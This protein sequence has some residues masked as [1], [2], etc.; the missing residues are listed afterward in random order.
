MISWKENDKYL[1]GVCN[2]LDKIPKTMKIA[3]FDLDDTI[4][5]LQK[6]KNSGWQFIDEKVKTTMNDLIEKK[7]M[8]IIFTNQGGMTVSKN[9]D[10]KGWRQKINEI[11]KI[12]FADHAQHYFAIFAAKCYDMFRKPN[13][14]MWKVM[15]KSLGGEI[16]DKSF[17]CGDAAGR[18][19]KDVYGKKADFSDTDRKFALNIGLPFYTPEDVFIRNFKI[20][21]VKYEL[22]GINPKKFL[23][24][25]CDS[26][27]EFKPRKKE[28]LLIVGF[29]GSGKSEFVKK[30]ILPHNYE[31]VN[32]DIHKTK[33]KCIKLTRAALEKDKSV[34]I[35]NTNLDYVSRM[36][37]V[38]IGLE[39]G[40]KRIRCIQIDIDFEL[41]KHLNNVRHIYSDGE[42]S[43]IS[44]IAY[45]MMKKKYEVPTTE[46]CF[47]KVEIIKFCFDSEKLQDK[48]WKTTF[49]Q[50]S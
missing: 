39:F 29:P 30:Y 38:E 17:Y 4:I 31:Y 35:D 24:N 47:D 11:Y 2:N 13:V 27:Y 36:T 6:G 23:K 18:L 10:M 33:A 20:K 7:Y 41:A 32:R 50:L 34:V 25:I 28:L 16:S 1:I 8:I 44:D 40:Y 22:S 43:K 15:T 49:M 42:V 14:G 21:D 45:N 48:K 37:Y 3:A 9:F 12:L 26:E 46:E 19:D 5:R